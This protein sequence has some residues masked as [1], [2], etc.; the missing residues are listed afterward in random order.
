MPRDSFCGLE[1]VLVETTQKLR[2]AI[3]EPKKAVDLDRCQFLDLVDI[4]C[5]SVRSRYRLS[6]Q[7]DASLLELKSRLTAVGKRRNDILHSAWWGLK[8]GKTMQRRV[9]A[10]DK[11]LPK[12][13]EHAQIPLHALESDIYEV[14]DLHTEIP[15]LIDWLEDEN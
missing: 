2:A 15:F 8:N 4:F 7:A 9:R 1:T 12:R 14:I 11:S 10:S 6:E 3:Q 13:V 5:K